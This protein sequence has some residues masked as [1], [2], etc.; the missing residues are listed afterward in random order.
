MLSLLLNNTQEDA[1]SREG[2]W[3]CP[4]K[5]PCYSSV[6]PFAV[7]NH[8]QGAAEECKNTTM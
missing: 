8:W 4:T 7:S 3:L 6:R 1:N 5:N 2:A